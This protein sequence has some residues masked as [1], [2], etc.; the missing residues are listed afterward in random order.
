MR[1]S[2]ARAFGG[3]EFIDGE[4]AK[5]RARKPWRLMVASRA[6]R[7]NAAWTKWHGLGRRHPAGP[8]GSRTPQNGGRWPIT[9]GNI[10]TEKLIWANAP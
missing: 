6:S 9:S 3:L 2:G 4:P 10:P 5:I 8:I 7:P 1:A